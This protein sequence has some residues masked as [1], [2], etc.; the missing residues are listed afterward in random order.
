ME[1]ETNII[2]SILTIA[3]TILSG[4][5]SWY[6]KNKVAVTKI[7]KANEFLT[8]AH[9]ELFVKQTWVAEAVRYAEQKFAASEGAKKYD[10][11]INVVAKKAREFG[12]EVTADELE[13]LI[14]AQVHRIKGE[15]KQT[16]NDIVK[17]ASID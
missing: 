5:T 11:V 7:V 15:A 13:V 10:E 8:K 2:L 12:L 1:T 9:N 4:V 16:W 14:E 6:L 17:D 3:G